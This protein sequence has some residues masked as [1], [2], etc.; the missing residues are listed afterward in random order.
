H[1]GTTAD[2]EPTGTTRIGTSSGTDFTTGAGAPGTTW[3]RIVAVDA[4]GNR[5]PA[6][7]AV[8]VVVPDTTAPA[9]PDGL[10]AS[11]AGSTAQ[12]SWAA[13]TDD[14]E[15]T[16]YQVHRGTSA[17]FTPDA[18]TL[19]AEVA[20]THYD[21]TELEPRQYFYKVVAFDAAGNTSEP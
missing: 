13:A 10:T 5:S 19:V 20:T 16:G 12:L 18:D 17:D 14:V 4:T 2:F 11:L 1:G 21:D 8:E 15:V 7:S 6:S 3:V 9:A